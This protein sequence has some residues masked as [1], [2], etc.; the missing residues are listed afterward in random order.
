[1]LGAADICHC[2][3]FRFGT[4]QMRRTFKNKYAE[5]YCFFLRQLTEQNTIISCLSLQKGLLAGA[6]C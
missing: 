6:W 4:M 5:V 2:E 3:T 1:M